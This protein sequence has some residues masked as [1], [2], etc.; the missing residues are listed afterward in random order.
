[1][2]RTIPSWRMVVQAE[3][4]KLEK[5]RD[6]LP[7][8]DKLV[9]HDLLLECRLY[10]PYASVMASPVKELPLLISM[11]FGQHKR[12]LELEK[13]IVTLETLMKKNR[14][15]GLSPD[16]QDTTRARPLMQSC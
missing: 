7:V 9:F 15:S 12:I 6:F 4:A 5:F 2:G 1:L 14:H 8:D 3:T 16:V 11:L 10:A 13:K